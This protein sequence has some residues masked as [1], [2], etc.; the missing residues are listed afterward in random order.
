MSNVLVRAE[1]LPYRQ[2][3]VAPA[4]ESMRP[5]NAF[6]YL[7]TRSQVEVVCVVE[8]QSDAKCFD[9]LR[10]EAFDS[11]LGSNRHEGRKHSDTV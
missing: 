6:Q 7:G 10:C 3:I 1:Y 9:L 2:E 5:S 11:G 8:N 4:L